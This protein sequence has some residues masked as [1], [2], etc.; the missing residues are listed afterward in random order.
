M[1]HPSPE[2]GHFLFSDYKI[3]HKKKKYYVDFCAGFPLFGPRGGRG[4]SRSQN[5]SM[6]MLDTSQPPPGTMGAAGCPGALSVRAA[7]PR[8]G[9]R[10]A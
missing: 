7:S 3:I 2:I 6:A 4:D 1:S 8:P 5:Q 9:R 10:P